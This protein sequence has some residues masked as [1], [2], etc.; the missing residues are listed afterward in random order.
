LSCND[1]DP[2]VREAIYKQINVNRQIIEDGNK[3]IKPLFFVV[4]EGKT[5]RDVA[6][7]ILFFLISSKK[8]YKEFDTL[9][10]IDDIKK[11]RY[12]DSVSTVPARTQVINWK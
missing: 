7:Y 10:F 2:P 5:V 11:T 9:L 12:K 8:A 3:Y 4:L 6:K 1:I